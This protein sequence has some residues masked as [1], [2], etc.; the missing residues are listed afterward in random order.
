MNKHIFFLS[1]T[2]RIF[3]Q[4]RWLWC[5]CNLP[6]KVFVIVSCVTRILQ[7]IKEQAFLSAMF[8][9]ALAH[10]FSCAYIELW[11][12]LGSLES[13]QEA[14]VAVPRATLTHLLCSPNFP[15]TSMTRY[16]HAKHEQILKFNSFLCLGRCPLLAEGFP[17]A[18]YFIEFINKFYSFTLSNFIDICT[19]A[20]A[21]S[22]PRLFK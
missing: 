21:K 7:L 10:A 16:T 3:I 17:S 9:K 15:C 22:S 6:I 11:M 19:Y 4:T 8:I 5:V 1:F 2:E 18:R 14:R 13:T 12:H 20:H